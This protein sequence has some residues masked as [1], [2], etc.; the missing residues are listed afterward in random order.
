MLKQNMGSIGRAVY[1]K[2]VEPNLYHKSAGAKG[3]VLS[4]DYITKKASVLVSETKSGIKTEFHN[5]PVEDH[6][7][8][9]KLTSLKPG[10]LVW[11]SFDNPASPSITTIFNA[12][13]KLD[14]IKVHHGPQVP[15]RLGHL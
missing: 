4:Y 8:G 9:M 11:V 5:I 6:G 1:D 14:D 3:V 13:Q 10:A 12:R 15:R 2:V 7:F